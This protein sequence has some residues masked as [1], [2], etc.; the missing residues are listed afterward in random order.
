MHDPV[1]DDDL[2]DDDDEGS[3]PL[4][5]I[6][7]V[8]LS[9]YTHHG[10]E[11]LA[12]MRALPGLSVFAPGDPIETELITT[13]LL[14]LPG[15]AYLR[16]GKASEPAVHEARPELVPGRA[17]LLQDGSDVTLI[18]TGGMLFA[19]REAA[20]ELAARHGL[21]VRLLSM[22]TLKPLDELSV[23]RAANETRVVV[24]CEEHSCIGGL[25][26]AVADVLAAL[27]APR[28]RLVKFAL[29][30]RP[31]EVVGSQRYL[32]SRLGS[33]VERMQQ[34][35]PELFAARALAV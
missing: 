14:D 1:D 29:P 26:S 16:L 20:R 8:G 10:V 19:A 18:A 32:L 27:P 4:V 25:G 28:A 3:E 22:H 21:S 11:D 2:H 33:I 13:A 7:I 17:H 31:S 15:P 34:Q 35:A 24:T 23:V 12:V 6:E 9:L 30:D 5:T